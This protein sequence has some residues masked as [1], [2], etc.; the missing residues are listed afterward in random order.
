MRRSNTLLF[1]N[2]TNPWFNLTDGK[3]V[4]QSVSRVLIRLLWKRVLDAEPFS[5]VHR[6]L[7]WE[8]DALT[9]PAG[10]MENHII[11]SVYVPVP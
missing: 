1:A 4:L 7:I 6:E 10:A 2:Q 3:F 8:V 11:C 9:L 5:L